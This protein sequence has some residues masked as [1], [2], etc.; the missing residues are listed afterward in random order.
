MT[1]S[2]GSVRLHLRPGPPL[3]GAVLP[4][5]DKSITHRAILLALLARGESVIRRPNRGRDCEATLACARAVGLE[6]RDD[7]DAWRLAGTGGALREADR[8][9]DCGNSGTTLRLL[10]GV[11]AAHPFLSIL[12][13]DASLHRRPVRRIVDPLRRMGAV[14][15]ARAGDTL[16]PLVVRGGPLRGVTLD[17]PVASAQIASSV[18]L[19]GLQGEGVTEVTLPGAAR[20][21]TERMLVPFGVVAEVTPGAHGGRRT[22]LEGPRVPVAADVT[23]PGDF[24]AAAFFLAAAAAT[25]G[26]EV[27]ATGVSLNPT[28]TGLL[29]VLERMGAAVERR[30]TASDGGEDRGDVIVRGPERLAATDI[31]TDWLPRLID[32]VPAWAMAAATARGVSRLRG[33]AELRVKESD[34]LSMLATGLARLGV[35]VVEHPD[36]LDIEG[37]GVTGGTIQAG[38]DHRIA[39]AFAVLAGS[40]GADVTIEE[41]DGIETSYPGFVDTLG[42][43]GG[44]VER[45]ENSRRGA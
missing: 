9:L 14:L 12:S 1:E 31:P 29:D 2:P 45:I 10:A 41:A 22:R 7:G 26:G 4:P 20:D 21:H 34:R 13:G 37:G 8:V 28:R 36:G 39:M 40:A 3:R 42:A 24:S 19:A 5:G 25:P 35:R 6:A 32:E 17:V 16:P 11:L 30:A 38:H 23:V 33:A 43:L 27:T 44:R 15:S 18:L